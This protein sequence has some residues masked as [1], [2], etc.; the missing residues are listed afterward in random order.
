MKEQKKKKY[1]APETK[2]TQVELEAGI[3]AASVIIT[4]PERNGGI[5]EHETNTDFNGDFSSDTWDTN[6]IKP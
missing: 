6:P 5:T 2:K 1:E 4:N 3:C